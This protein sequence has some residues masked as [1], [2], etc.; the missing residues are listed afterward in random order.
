[1]TAVEGELL[2][3]QSL[4]ETLMDNVPEQIYFKDTDGRFLRVSKAVA[5]WH[6]LS[7]PDEIPGKTDLDFFTEEHA[8]AAYSDEQKVMKS[9]QAQV[10][11]EE[12][13]TWLDGRETWV[14]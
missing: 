1:E 7:D 3:E 13:E 5:D 4:L 6:G 2:Q 12:R 8:Q 14:S 11:K 10:D 9:G